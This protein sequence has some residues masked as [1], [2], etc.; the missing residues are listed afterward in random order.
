MPIWL[1]TTEPELAIDPQSG[2][3]LLATGD[4]T[5]QHAEALVS[6]LSE[7]R[8]GAHSIDA[9]G[10]NRIDATGSQ[11]LMAF[12]RR[13]G[14]AEQQLA[15]K[16]EHQALIDAVLSASDVDETD[17]AL[18]RHLEDSRRLD[19]LLHLHDHRD[20]GDHY[21]TNEGRI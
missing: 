2:H 1:E 8:S 15:A 5:F 3:C 4:W 11:L 20:R 7:K 19:G 12:L 17:Q 13:Q 10:I 9:R 18:I 14:I 16:P 6:L 21:T